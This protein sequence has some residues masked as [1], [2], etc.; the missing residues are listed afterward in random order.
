MTRYRAEL[1]AVS[2]PLDITWM[3]I[4]FHPFARHED[5]P[6]VPKLRYPI[7]ERYLPTRGPRA[8]DMMRR[9]CTV[10]ANVDYDSE[11]DAMRKLRLSLAV[12]PV[13]TAMFANSPVIEGRLTD[14][15][16]E[17]AA[18]WIG[19]DPDRS[20]L[21]PFAWRDNATLRD[22]VEWALDV[23]M[24]LIRRGDVS[25]DAT[26]LTFRTFM[27]DG[28]SGHAATSS[29]WE[30]HLNTLFPEVRLKRTIELRGADAPPPA[31]SCAVAALWKGLLYDDRS[32]DAIERAV[33]SL[34][35]AEVER[36]RPEVAARALR[37]T[38]GG[39]SMQRWAEDLLDLAQTALVRHAVHDAQGRDESLYLQ[40]I[41]ALVERG[42]TPSD[43]LRERIESEGDLARA[44]IAHATARD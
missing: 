29:D 40:G 28:L 38:L 7:M 16:C 26:H 42:Q 10:Q 32:L 3:S 25:L 37:A 36:I 43:V 33:A 21:L 2:A 44:V 15:A 8:L 41:R 18:T 6:H 19:M 9:T 39:R 11:A 13:V 30:T 14:R 17:R 35:P 22:Y 23:P 20:G 27:T 4:G 24:F 31:L 34:H 12:Q 5:L 1:H